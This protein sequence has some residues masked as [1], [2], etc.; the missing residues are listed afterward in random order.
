MPP[1]RRRSARWTTSG[2]TRRGGT[3]RP[4]ATP[5]TSDGF[6]PTARFANMLATSGAFRCDD[7]GMGAGSPNNDWRLNDQEVSALVAGTHRDPFARLGLQQHDGAWIARAVVPG[8]ERVRVTTLAGK[9]AGELGRRGDTRFFEG[10]LEVPG[11][12]PLRILAANAGAEWS[13][14]DPCS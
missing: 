2:G 5:P 6:P 11:R 12:T 13:F 10:R 9:P 4:S 14:I 7:R 3:A 8:A 1:M